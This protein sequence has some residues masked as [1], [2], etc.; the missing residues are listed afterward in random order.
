MSGEN[1]VTN[2]EHILFELRS[3]K[4]RMNDYDWDYRMNRFQ[5]RLD[6]QRKEI[7]IILKEMREQK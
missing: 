4:S 3:V 5:E 6:N 1:Q 2:K 7:S